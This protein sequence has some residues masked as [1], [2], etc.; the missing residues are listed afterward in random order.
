MSLELL[1]LVRSQHPVLV[2][3]CAVNSTISALMAPQVASQQ[4]ICGFRRLNF[5][6]HQYHCSAPE[7][8]HHIWHELVSLHLLCLNG[9]RSDTG[10]AESSF[11]D[12]SMK[13]FIQVWTD[14]LKAR[15]KSKE[16]TPISSHKSDQVCSKLDSSSEEA[17]FSQVQ[18]LHR[19][20]LCCRCL[21]KLQ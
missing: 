17:L 2:P 4:H 11:F 5:S 14:Y 10:S 1:I 18:I 3:Q 21:H 12:R 19:W 9:L 7:W 16:A 20:R 13:M 15:Y 6:L 8:L